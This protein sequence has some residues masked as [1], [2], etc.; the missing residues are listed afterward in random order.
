[1]EASYTTQPPRLYATALM[2]PSVEHLAAAFVGYQRTLDFFRKRYTDPENVKRIEVCEQKLKEAESALF[3]GFFGRRKI[4]LAWGL[5][6]QI[7]E[8]VFLLLN[9]EELIAEGRQ[10]LTNL[11]TA[12]IPDVSREQWTKALITELADLEAT[13][14]NLARAQNQFKMA[15]VMLN[16]HVDSRFWDLWSS[17]LSALIYTILLI[18]GLGLLLVI[19][20]GGSGFTCALANVFLLGAI[21]GVAS[22]ILTAEPQYLAKGHLWVSTLYYSLVRPAQGALAALIVFWLIQSQYLIT[23]QPPVVC[24]QGVFGNSAAVFQHSSSARKKDTETL[25]VLNAAEGS[26]GYL[27]MLVLLLSGFSGDKI[28]KSVSDKVMSRLFDAAE[29][30]KEL[31]KDETGK[32]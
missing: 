30:T 7:S 29:K 17:K 22:G 27:L 26:Q 4:F 18:A 24:K 10:L 15:M 11:S 12:P 5:L 6:H 20:G 1:M 9:R 25:I 13:G 3:P 2:N 19:F 14:V 32:K 16:N 23:I 8:D 28:L 21:G 31:P